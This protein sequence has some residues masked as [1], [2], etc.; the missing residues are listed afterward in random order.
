M[1]ASDIILLAGFPLPILIALS[2]SWLLI[3]KKRTV[4]G[5]VAGPIAILLLL[6]VFIFLVNLH[7]WMWDP[8]TDPLYDIAFEVDAFLLAIAVF[9]A[10]LDSFVVFG[11]NVLL[12][13]IYRL[14][15]H[16]GATTQAS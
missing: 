10:A 1:D 13:L 12:A 11:I 5:I 4:L 14:F 8:K 7:L 9:M 6:L 15:R 16:H 3:H 2:L